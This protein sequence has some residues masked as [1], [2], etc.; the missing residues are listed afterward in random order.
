MPGREIALVSSAG[1]GR[2]AARVR[3]YCFLGDFRDNGSHCLRMVAE[4]AANF[5]V[6][7]WK[8]SGEKF[9]P[10]AP[11]WTIEVISGDLN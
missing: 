3:G 2:Q 4:L 11:G 6:F 1:I 9:Y 8:R 5:S 7:L 10:G